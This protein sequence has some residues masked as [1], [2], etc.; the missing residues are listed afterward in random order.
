MDNVVVEIEMPA[1]NQMRFSQL[2]GEGR[3]SYPLQSS[4]PFGPIP[5][6]SVPVGTS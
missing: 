3:N 4:V 6:E 2:L 5:L 1:S